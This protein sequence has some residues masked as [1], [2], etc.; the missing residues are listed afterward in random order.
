[1][2]YAKFPLVTVFTPGG[3][4][5]NLLF[6]HSALDTRQLICR[7]TF[8]SGKVSC[9][10]T[11]SV[12]RGPGKQSPPS[13]QTRAI[14]L[15]AV[16]LAS[17]STRESAGINSS[18]NSTLSWIGILSHDRSG[19]AFFSRTES[20]QAAAHPWPTIA[21]CFILRGAFLISTVTVT[22]KHSGGS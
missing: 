18:G 19:T 21:S 11:C 15:P 20:G 9:M 4:G 8:S 2:L 3:A 17:I 12:S 1:M 14:D 5:S 16:I 10:R 6:P 13:F 7:E 22:L